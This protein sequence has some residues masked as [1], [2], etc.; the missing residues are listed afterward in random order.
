MI[1]IINKEKIGEIQMKL[2]DIQNTLDRRQADRLAITEP[3]RRIFF[4]RRDET[5]ALIVDSTINHYQQTGLDNLIQGFVENV[6]AGNFD[7]P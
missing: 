3:D 4:R 5:T 2:R 1:A 6:R 7:E